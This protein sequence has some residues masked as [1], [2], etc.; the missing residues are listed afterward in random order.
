MRLP[1]SSGLD[2]QAKLT[3][4]GNRMPIIFMT[5]HGDVP[6]S[7]QAMK[8]GALDFLTKP[9]RDQDMLDAITVA[10]ERDKPGAPRARASPNSKRWRPP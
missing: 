4:R 6:M 9:F 3:A 1:G 10:I 7:V 5:G 8:A 2:L